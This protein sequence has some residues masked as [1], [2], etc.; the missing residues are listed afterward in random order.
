MYLKTIIK[1]KGDNIM[2]VVI[3]PHENM[4]RF[5]DHSSNMNFQNVIH[6]IINDKPEINP[7]TD[8]KRNSK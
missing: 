5:I 8:I 7:C 1:N 3:L 2:P 4:K 6:R